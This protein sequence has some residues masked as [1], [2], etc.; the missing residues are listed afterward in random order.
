MKGARANSHQAH[1]MSL[2]TRI[3]RE[4][5]ANLESVKGAMATAIAETSITNLTVAGMGPHYGIFQQTPP[6]WGSLAAGHGS[7]VRNREVLLDL[8]ALSAQG[9]GLVD[10]LRSHSALGLSRCSGRVRGGGAEERRVFLGP[11]DRAPE[12]VV[13]VADSNADGSGGTTKRAVPYEFVARQQ[14][15]ELVGLHGA[16]G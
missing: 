2:I 8:P 12:V 3:G 15:R 10:G 7:R 14:G 1:N 6:T 16:A 13:A 4:K 5:G 9:R 11:A